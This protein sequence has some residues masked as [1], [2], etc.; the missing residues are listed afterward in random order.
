MIYIEIDSG[1]FKD[2]D[3][4]E[5][6]ERDGKMFNRQEDDNQEEERIANGIIGV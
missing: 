5:F 6:Y 3:G 4:T 2:E 1:I